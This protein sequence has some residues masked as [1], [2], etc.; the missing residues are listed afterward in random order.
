MAYFRNAKSKYGHVRRCTRSSRA[1][2][3]LIAGVQ[4]NTVGA[5]SIGTSTEGKCWKPTGDEVEGVDVILTDVLLYRE[6][7]NNTVSTMSRVFV[8]TLTPCIS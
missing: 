4:T 7:P 1:L 2:R 3:I 8:F 6:C 5:G